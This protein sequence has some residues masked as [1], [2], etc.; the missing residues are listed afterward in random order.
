MK[1]LLRRL[2]S[3]I[4]Q[5]LESFIAVISKPITSQVPDDPE[6]NEIQHV[7]DLSGTVTDQATTE[8]LSDI[9][10]Y[11]PGENAATTT[12][13][14]GQ[15]RFKLKPGTYTVTVDPSGFKEWAEEITV[16]NEDSN[17]QHVS[18]KLEPLPKKN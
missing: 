1:Y 18:V 13:D 10:V 14:N 9:N 12:D 3:F 2:V 5:S 7:I 4:I 11:L 6:S 16:A 17:S 15:F 8:A